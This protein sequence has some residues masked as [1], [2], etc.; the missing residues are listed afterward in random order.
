VELQTDL[1]WEGQSRDTVLKV[2]VDHV[3]VGAP[4]ANTF[5]SWVLVMIERR[6]GSIGVRFPCA[7]PG[8]RLWLPN[9]GPEPATLRSQ[10]ASRANRHSR[11]PRPQRRGTTS[12]RN[13]RPGR[14]SRLTGSRARRVGVRRPL[15]PRLHHGA[16]RGDSGTC[17]RR[18][19]CSVNSSSSHAARVNAVSRST[20]ACSAAVSAVS[21]L[22]LG[23]TRRDRVASRTRCSAAT[24][25]GSEFRSRSSARSSRLP[26]DSASMR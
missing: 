19:I 23:P 24:S 26:R 16:C 21:R 10:T 15:R 9:S 17:P 22:V 4:G 11:T 2:E 1:G 18:F 12:S 5:S 25:R 13:A 6:V 14:T 3:V 7:P 20:M 8:C